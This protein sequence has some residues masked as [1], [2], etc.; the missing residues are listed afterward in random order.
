VAARNTLDTKEPVTKHGSGD[1]GRL[2]ASTA[3]DF[4]Q[5][6]GGKDG[7]S[8]T[9]VTFREAV[10]EIIVSCKWCTT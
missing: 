7:A 9:T 1:V 8:V 3:G 5:Q 4:L 6:R 2:S 10:P